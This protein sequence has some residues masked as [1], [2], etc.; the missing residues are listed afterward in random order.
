M[1]DQ[2][3]PREMFRESRC[4]LGMFS[5]I[6]GLFFCVCVY[7]TEVWQPSTLTDKIGKF[8]V[9]DILFTFISLCGVGLIASVVGP[10]RIQP[11]IR[12]IGGKA[13][14]AGVVLMLGTLV[15]ILYYCLV[16]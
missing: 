2:R 8:A 14:S 15:W 10:Q 4:I 1:R 5:P 16:S 7:F 12:R 13:A 3:Q 11:L 9:E 6:L